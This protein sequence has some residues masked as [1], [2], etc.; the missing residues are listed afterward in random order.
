MDLEKKK[1][2]YNGGDKIGNNF[3]SNAFPGSRKVGRQTRE[4]R[5]T[6]KALSGSADISLRTV[7]DSFELFS[8]L[9]DRGSVNL[10]KGSVYRS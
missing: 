4:I 1:K 10:L 5:E 6:E 9:S 7:P 2:L 3:K 8:L